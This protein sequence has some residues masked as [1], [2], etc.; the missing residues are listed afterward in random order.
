MRKKNQEKKKERKKGRGLF[1]LIFLIGVGYLVSKEKNQM[2]E[3][4]NIITNKNTLAI[5]IEK[6]ISEINKTLEVE[7]NS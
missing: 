2:V 7:L 5:E 4:K 1:L 6:E 3:I